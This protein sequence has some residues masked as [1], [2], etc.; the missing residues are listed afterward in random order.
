MESIVKMLYKK[1]LN[2]LKISCNGKAFDVSRIKDIPIEQWVFPFCSKGVK[3]N[4]LYEEL[5][6]LTESNDFTLHFDSDDTSFEIVKY[7]LSETP[8]KLIGT[9]NIVTILYNENPFTTRITVNGNVFNTARIQNR[10]IDEWINPIQIRDLQWNGIFEELSEFIGT[11]IYKIYFV[12]K[13]E[14]MKLL[15]DKCPKNVDVFYRSPKIAEKD[16]KIKQPVKSTPNTASNNIPK[17]NMESVSLAAKKAAEKLKVTSSDSETSE[18]LNQ[19]PIKNAFIRKNIMSFCAL[20]SIIFAFLPF[21]SFSAKAG[22]VTGNKISVSGF[23]TLFGVNEIKVGSNSSIFGLILFL[24]PII[25]IV[26]NYIKPLK[27]FKKYIAVGAPVLGIIGE[28]ITFFDLRGTFKTFIQDEGAKLSSSLGIGFFLIL[29]SFI[30]TA[31]VGLMIYHG[32]QLPKNKKD[33]K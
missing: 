17:V 27:P 31:V 4:G 15:I 26:M 29:V 33:R 8:A 32:M 14:F 7:A 5:K 11:D 23:E 1:D 21:A 6:A 28:F 13:Q 18:N 12:G 30:L 24:V 3:W 25:I 2:I 20:I 19:I 10:S 9:N 22:D 16:N